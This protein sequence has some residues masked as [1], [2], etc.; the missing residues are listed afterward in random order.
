[1]LLRILVTAIVVGIAAFFTPGFSI[2]NIWS[3]LLAAVII[4]VLDY[5]IQ[6][7]TGVDATPFG[8]G[9]TGFIVAAIILYVTKFIVP[10]FNISVWGAIIGALV[11]GILDAIIPG[12]AM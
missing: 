6:K 4:G 2:D 1:M 8:R 11:I 10:G 5:L 9:I 7:F 3:L 12:R